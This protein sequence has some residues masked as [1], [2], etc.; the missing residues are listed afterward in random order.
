MLSN[1]MLFAVC[2]HAHGPRQRSWSCCEGPLSRAGAGYAR[3]RVPHGMPRTQQQMTLEKKNNVV[4]TIT[5]HPPNA[6]FYR[7]YKPFPNGW[8]IALFYPHY[9][10]SLVRVLYVSICELQTK[11]TPKNIRRNLFS[12]LNLPSLVRDILAGTVP[13]YSIPRA[14]A[15]H[16]ELHISRGAHIKLIHGQ[17]GPQSQKICAGKKRTCPPLLPAGWDRVE[18]SLW[19]HQFP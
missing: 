8:F 3:K 11:P 5:N 6:H 12:N 1:L 17:K 10:W 9:S 13:S 18:E 16:I 4:K 14:P 19:S 15:D 2:W 7:C